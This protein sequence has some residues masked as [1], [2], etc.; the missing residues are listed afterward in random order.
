MIELRLTQDE[1]DTIYEALTDYIT[2]TIKHMDFYK[3][4]DQKKYNYWDTEYRLARETLANI[5]G[6][7]EYD[8]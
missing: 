1:Y 7:D 5:H 6:K 8:V 2:S 4:E 3:H